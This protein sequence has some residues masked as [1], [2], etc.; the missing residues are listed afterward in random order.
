ME[1]AA[2][3]ELIRA[4]LKP[5]DQVMVRVPGT[6]TRAQADLIRAQVANAVEVPVMVMCRGTKV[7][8]SWPG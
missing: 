4:R 2:A 3:V 1:F 5:G 7:E 6:V 8:A